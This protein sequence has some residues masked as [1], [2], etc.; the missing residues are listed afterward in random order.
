MIDKEDYIEPRCL[1]CEPK[2]KERIPV[3]RVLEKLD[4]YFFKKDYSSAQNVLDYWTKEAENLEDIG[5][6]LSLLNE[7]VGLNR[8]LQNREKAFYYCEKCASAFDYYGFSE[9]SEELL[10][11][12]KEIYERT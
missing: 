5:G 2:K 6:K 3:Q 4:E 12:A 7:C 9:Y 1:F 10:K 8:K 11:R